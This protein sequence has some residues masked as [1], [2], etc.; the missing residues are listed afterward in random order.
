MTIS[1][2]WNTGLKLL[3]DQITSIYKNHNREEAQQLIDVESYSSSFFN[4]K[5]CINGLLNKIQDHITTNKNINEQTI[6][7]IRV[8]YTGNTI[9]LIIDSNYNL[10]EIDSLRYDIKKNV[11]N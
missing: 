8:E 10:T 2:I 4:P 7:I 9:Q 6:K 3:P 5:F 1:G 11:K